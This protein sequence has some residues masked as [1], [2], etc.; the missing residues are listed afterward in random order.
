MQ[1]NKKDF[2]TANI[3]SSRKPKDIFYALGNNMYV[4]IDNL[5]ED[6]WTEGFTDYDSLIS[7]LKN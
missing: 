7:W 1:I 4:G 2:L 3:K 5:N 6:A